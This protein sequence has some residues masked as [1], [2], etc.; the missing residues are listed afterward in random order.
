[1]ELLGKV[2]SLSRKETRL[3]GGYWTLSTC[4]VGLI[5]N[6]RVHKERLLGRRMEFRVFVHRRRPARY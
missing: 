4:G 2:W 6:D 3:D 5:A 1:M